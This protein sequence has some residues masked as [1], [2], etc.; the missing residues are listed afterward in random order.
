M[1]IIM[2]SVW[3]IILHCVCCVGI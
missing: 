3:M 1:I 2:I